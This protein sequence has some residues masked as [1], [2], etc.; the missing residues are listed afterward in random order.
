MIESICP[1]C[2]SKKVFGDDKEGK[3]FKCPTCKMTVSIRK[4]DVNS[5]M[6]KEES[7]EVDYSSKHQ[8][9]IGKLGLRFIIAVLFY[10]FFLLMAI[11]NEGDLTFKIV[12]FIVSAII[13]VLIFGKRYN[14]IK[15][16]FNKD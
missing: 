9:E 8:D 11:F 12:F 16:Q 3:K 7:V 13:I 15:D 10:I 14:K 6:E 5:L 1:K 4:I 2:G